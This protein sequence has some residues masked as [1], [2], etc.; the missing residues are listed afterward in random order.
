MKKSQLVEIIKEE[1]HTVLDEKTMKLD[2]KNVVLTINGDDDAVYELRPNS[3]NIIKL[4]KQFVEHNTDGLTVS[5]ITLDIAWQH[6]L[7]SSQDIIDMYHK[8]C[9]K[10]KRGE[11]VGGQDDDEFKCNRC[12]HK[13]PSKIS[14]SDLTNLT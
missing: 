1:I 6:D 7:D 4:I 9:L 11:Y 14:Q 3:L 2:S 13:I 5:A 10:C 12:A 8:K